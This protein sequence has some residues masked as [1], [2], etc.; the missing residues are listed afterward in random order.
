MAQLNISLPDALKSWAERRVAEGRYGS[1][2]DY[3]RDLVR[4]DQEA[5]ERK[6]ADDERLRHAW[7][8]GLTSGDAVPMSDDWADMVVARGRKRSGAEPDVA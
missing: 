5:Q 6:A 1:T 8:T 7:E 4:R 2:S 3:V